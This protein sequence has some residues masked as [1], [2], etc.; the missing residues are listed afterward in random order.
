MPKAM[1]PKHA[2]RLRTSLL[3]SAAAALLL[4]L[5]LAG[6]A[7]QSGGM[8]DGDAQPPFGGPDSVGYAGDLWHRLQDARLVGDNTIHVTPYV[9]QEPHG[10]ILETMEGS[11]TVNGVTGPAIVKKNYVGDGLT[12]EQVINNYD[13]HLDSVTV[14]F[15]RERGYDP[16]H[17]DWFWVKYNPDGS[18]Q[19]NPKGMALAGRVAKGAPKGCIACHQ[20]APGNDYIFNHDRY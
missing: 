5:L 4:A 14:M 8:S 3:L 11:L 16:D 9:G 19:K 2:L 18:V 10:A 15:K 13:R 6:C 17:Q 12:K 7:Q 20:A 1:R